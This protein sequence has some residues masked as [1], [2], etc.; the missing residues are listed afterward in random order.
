MVGRECVLA[1]RLGRAFAMIRLW[2]GMVEARG[3]LA[4]GRVGGGRA[5]P[6]NP[7]APPIP[8]YSRRGALAVNE[9]NDSRRTGRAFHFTQ[10]LYRW[11][12]I[13]VA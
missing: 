1:G 11:V 6:T 2:A 13:L 4:P 10:G 5:T 12:A 8:H 9:V 7:R 3:P